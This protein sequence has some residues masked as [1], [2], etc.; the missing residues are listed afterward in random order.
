MGVVVD[1]GVGVGVTVGL[2]FTCVCGAVRACACVWQGSSA[3]Y[4][5]GSSGEGMHMTV[6]ERKVMARQSHITSLPL[7]QNGAKSGFEMCFAI[8]IGSQQRQSVHKGPGGKTRLESRIKKF[9]SHLIH[10][11]KL[12]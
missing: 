2:A 4:L 8:A 11:P 1:V 3:F 10:R 6:S 5:C 9:K 7:F 12:L